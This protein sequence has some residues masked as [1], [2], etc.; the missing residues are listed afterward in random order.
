LSRFE[1][2]FSRRFAAS[3]KAQ[4]SE[5]FAALYERTHL[6]VFRYIYA[7]HGEPQEDVEDIWLETYW[8]AWR[9]WSHFTGSDEAALGWLLHIA[10]NLIF[11]Q[12]RKA[13]RHRV[14]ELHDAEALPAPH[15][16]APE[17][18]IIA[19]EQ[20]A[21]LWQML[22]SLP[23]PQREMVVLRYMLGWR[24]KDIARHQHLPENTVSVTLRRIIAR[25]AQRQEEWHD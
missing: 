9:A 14:S 11:D 17:Y 15:E 22:K 16:N 1:L 4:N 6:T 3:P 7:L 10:R 23:V 13:R 12:Q 21:A 19:R 25:L 24:V 8:K 18:Q 20:H 2:K 5:A